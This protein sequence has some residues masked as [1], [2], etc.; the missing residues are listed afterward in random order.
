MAS[1]GAE[2]AAEGCPFS[3]IEAFLAAE[4]FC[5]ECVTTL[6]RAPRETFTPHLAI[7]RSVLLKQ[8]GFNSCPASVVR[9]QFSSPSP[10][11]DSR[12][13]THRRAFNH[14]RDWLYARRS[15]QPGIPSPRD[16]LFFGKHTTKIIKLPCPAAPHP[17]AVPCSTQK[18]R[19]CGP[20]Q[21]GQCDYRPAVTPPL[22][23]CVSCALSPPPSLSCP[24]PS[25]PPPS[26]PPGCA[27][28]HAPTPNTAMLSLSAHASSLTPFPPATP[29][30]LA[31]Q[32]DRVA[33][34]GDARPERHAQAVQH[35]RRASVR[36][37]RVGVLE[38][39]GG[40]A[41]VGRCGDVRSDRRAPQPRLVER[42]AGQQLGQVAAG[43]A[44]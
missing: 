27:P 9:V 12:Q 21:Q 40:H 19:A 23:L 43:G 25:P 1:D 39:D 22:P 4:L 35:I 28:S 38:G 34:T 20:S 36:D 31:P 33:V 5:N 13:G 18:T 11:L 30:P 8:L 10:L 3:G 44:H 32:T 14:R 15:V 17:H 16:D 6:Q 42:A 29:S 41:S 26:L 37:V 2:A 7:Y 24:P